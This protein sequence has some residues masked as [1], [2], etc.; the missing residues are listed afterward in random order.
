MTQEAKMPPNESP[1]EQDIEE[2]GR[3]FDE[4]FGTLL[5]REKLQAASVVVLAAEEESET[6]QVEENQAVEPLSEE[7]IEAF[8]VKLDGFHDS[9][10][11]GQHQILDSMVARAFVHGVPEDE[12]DDVQGNY[13]AW[14]RFVP[15]NQ[16][17]NQ[18]INY[19][20]NFCRNQ[21]GVLR[22]GMSTRNASGV[23]GANVGCWR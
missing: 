11:E 5:D 23:W 16:Y 22:Q 13:W 9:L 10:P 1:S 19:Y 2:F 14:V 18:W 8:T 20:N 17:Q 12:Q 7:E 4:W 6:E 21:G 3:K 15:Y